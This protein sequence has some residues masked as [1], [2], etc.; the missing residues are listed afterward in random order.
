MI[1]TGVLAVTVVALA[2][3]KNGRADERA[4]PAAA[5]RTT[6][7]PGQLM[8]VALAAL[9]LTRGARADAGGRLHVTE[10]TMRA[11]APGSHGDAAALRFVFDGDSAERVALASGQVRRQL[12]LKLRAADG[13]NLI[14]VMWRLDPTPAIEVSTK[15][16]P[17]DRDH[18]DCGTRG[19]TKVNPVRSEAPPA[20]APGAT[21]TLAAEIIGDELTARVDDRVVWRGRLDAAA[22][23]LTG[24]A[25]MRSDN[26]GFD[27]ELLVAAADPASPR[28]AIPGCD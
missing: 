11:V 24:P 9:C 23:A 27:V 5:A 1:R 4:R 12:G 28:L 3:C 16:N 26:L 13:C 8:P 20:L 14:Y 19:Y 22:G 17:G 15:I 21:H 25:G 18:G 2:A 10:P 7:P 6:S